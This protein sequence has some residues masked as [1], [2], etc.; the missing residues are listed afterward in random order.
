MSIHD[1]LDRLVHLGM[2]IPDREQAGHCLLHIG[3]HRLSRYWQPFQAPS[4]DGGD[5]VFRAGAEFSN[6]IAHYV[7]DGHLRSTVADALGQIEVSAR[8]LWAGYLSDEG[9]S[10]AHL[11]QTLFT[12]ERYWQHLD[13]LKQSYQ[14]AAERDNPN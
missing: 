7:F 13:D 1:Q 5:Q 9:G 2:A 10:Q 4:T 8:A 3:Y 11:N 12:G 14:R 6:V